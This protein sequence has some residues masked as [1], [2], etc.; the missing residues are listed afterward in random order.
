MCLSQLEILAKRNL[1]NFSYSTWHRACLATSFWVTCPQKG[2]SEAAW[3][4]YR[5]DFL[6]PR[7]APYLQDNASFPSH[8]SSQAGQWAAC[9]RKSITSH[10]C[11]PWET[12]WP[13]YV[14][15]SF[16]PQIHLP[17]RKWT[18]WSKSK[19]FGLQRKQKMSHSLKHFTW[20]L[21]PTTT[22]RDLTGTEC[23]QRWGR[24]LAWCQWPF[25]PEKFRNSPVLICWSKVAEKEGI[26]RERR[27]KASQTQDR[28][29]GDREESGQG[30]GEELC[31]KPERNDAQHHPLPAWQ[32][33]PPK[34]GWWHPPLEWFP[35][36]NISLSDLKHNHFQPGSPYTRNVRSGN[37]PPPD[38][39]CPAGLSARRGPEPTFLKARVCLH[40]TLPGAVS[41]PLNQTN[42]HLFLAPWHFLHGAG[43]GGG[44]RDRPWQRQQLLADAPW[45]PCF[46]E[47]VHEHSCSSWSC[48]WRTG[49]RDKEAS[50]VFGKLE[51][52][53]QKM[54]FLA[55]RERCADLGYN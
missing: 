36:A 33:S 29:P 9:S 32:A 43:G 25:S 26:G 38:P 11:F 28:W 37:Y 51:L 6:H 48:H 8:C 5:G 55:L 18:F 14:L 2:K 17:P 44:E 7:A 41:K 46:A 23:S 12:V 34:R 30:S 53:L 22:T 24:S 16:S 39:L 21:P 19:R 13:G 15:L 50:Q 27:G 10:Y 3:H 20:L 35:P 4:L 31:Q 47:G 54:L 52:N 1:R 40:A 45:S 42:P 49:P